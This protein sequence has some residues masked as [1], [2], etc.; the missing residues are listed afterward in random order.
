MTIIPTILHF[1]KEKSIMFV[2]IQNKAESSLALNNYVTTKKRKKKMN[3]K[4]HLFSNHAL[5]ML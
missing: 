2:I 5:K 1:L 4:N 3:E